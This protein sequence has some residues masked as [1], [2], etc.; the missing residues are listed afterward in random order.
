MY[1]LCDIGFNAIILTD[2]PEIKGVH[3][4]LFI[5]IMLIF[6]FKKVSDYQ[7]I[8]HWQRIQGTERF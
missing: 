6:S 8:T 3:V 2:D 4:E 7:P 1:K 5:E